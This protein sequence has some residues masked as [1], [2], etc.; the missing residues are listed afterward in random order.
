[1]DFSQALLL[2]KQ[3]KK[4][5]RKIAHSKWSIKGDTLVEKTSATEYEYKGYVCRMPTE[6]ILA[7]DW[8]E[9]L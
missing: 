1:M 4:V 8:E 7:D 6:S 5:K 3:G 2:M 9:C